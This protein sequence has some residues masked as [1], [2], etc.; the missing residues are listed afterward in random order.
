MATPRSFLAVQSAAATYRRTWRGSLFVTIVAPVL[1]LSSMGLGLGDLIDNQVGSA[2]TLGGV[3]YLTFLA[4]GLLAM[5]AMQTASVEATFPV[6]AG[7]RW[8]KSYFAMLATPLTV[9][10]VAIGTVL[11]AGVRVAMTTVLFVIVMVLFG[12]TSS[13]LGTLLAMFAAVLTGMAFVAP[14]AAA[15]ASVKSEYGIS[16]ILRFGI[17]PM[18]LFSGAFFPVSTLP[19]A[20]R[21]VA[22]VTPS[23]H[24]VDLCRSLALG[25][26]GVL[27]SLGHVVYLAVWAAAGTRLAVWRFERRLVT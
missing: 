4:P 11:W 12:A 25:R 8:R 17:T 14:L 18:F 26:A 22:Y 3:D 19:A 20:M 5:T 1:F 10:D 24:G 21:V 23:W 2:A 6:M 9:S 27:A 16:S 13:W 15:T 7:I